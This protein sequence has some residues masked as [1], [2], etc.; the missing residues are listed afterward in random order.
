MYSVEVEALTK[1][2][3]KF[4]AVDGVSFSVCK[5]EIFV[6]L[7]PNGAGKSTTIRMLCGIL[8]PT[9]GKGTVEGF[10]I[11][12][13]PDSIKEIIGYMSQK[14]SLYNDLTVAENIEFY[15]GIHNVPGEKMKERKNWILDMAGL[16]GK[17]TALTS[18]LSGGWKQRLALGCSII[19]NPRV[20]FLDE[21]TAGVDPISRRDFWKLIKELSAAGTTVFV[22]THYM[23]E[24]E[25]CGKIS[26]IYRGKL[27]ALGAPRELKEK[28]A[29]ASLEHLFV[30][31][32]KEYDQ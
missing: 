19:H 3:G 24:A 27:I 30:K 10:D 16:K 14:F 31:L 29:A 22:T 4:T 8:E 15:G 28:N 9:A 23:D 12:K 13:E 32:I 25:N 1:V 11:K 5:G 21:P 18:A 17:E 20:L 26:L 6:F 7:G 2:F